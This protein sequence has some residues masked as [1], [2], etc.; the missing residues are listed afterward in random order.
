MQFFREKALLFTTL[1][2]FDSG[3]IVLKLST[4]ILFHKFTGLFVFDVDFLFSRHATPLS[5]TAEYL[6]NSL[7]F[8]LDDY[9]DILYI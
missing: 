7:V 3:I 6:T 1:S 9:Y 2:G 8:S 5:I 4:E